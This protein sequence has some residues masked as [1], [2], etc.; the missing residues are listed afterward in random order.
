MTDTIGSVPTVCL[1]DHTPSRSTPYILKRASHRA[2]EESPFVVVPAT[3]EH[4]RYAEDI[5]DLIAS[6][7]EKRGTGIA[8]RTPEYV[9]QKMTE[10]K[11]VIALRG[12]QVAGFCYIESWGHGRF[13]ANSGLI[14]GEEFRGSGLAR[15][16]KRET[17]L[18]S[19]RRY[20]ASKIFSITTSL[21]VMK[22]NSNLGYRPVTFSELTD[23][24]EFWNGCKSC[25]NYDI[26]ERNDQ[27]MCL[28]TGMLY[29]PEATNKSEEF[30][31]EQKA[32]IL[33]RLRRMKRSIF[34][35]KKREEK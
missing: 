35:G 30:P 34:L 33:E 19:R 7:A 24:Q 1:A 6:A 32:G 2:A 4:T 14:V 20:P 18:L 21:A 28:C 16:I 12:D 8:R 31:F 26:L 15:R 10:G 9:A 5:C 22:L 13:V 17:F 25:R 27:K 3:S 23:D 29:N 11:G